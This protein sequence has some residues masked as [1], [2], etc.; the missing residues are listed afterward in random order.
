MIHVLFSSSAAGTLR[1]VLRTRG[2]GHEK[3]IDLTELLDWGPIGSGDPQ[4]RVRWLDRNVPS[5]F[6]GGWDWLAEHVAEFEQRVAEEPDRLI[7]IEPYS[8]GE[9]SGLYWYLERFAGSD[10]QMLIAPQ[11][12]GL[13][14]LGIRGPESMADLLDNCPRVPWEHGRFPADHW[15]ALRAENL[16]LR[17]GNDG[18]LLST[19]SDYFDHFLLERCSSEWTPWMRVVGNAMIDIGDA[20]HR[21]DDVFLRWRLRELILREMIAS[22]GDMP[23][24]GAQ[25]DTLVRL[26]G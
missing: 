2:G 19:A 22:N 21:I 12:E 10:T 11:F 23:L 9:L 17:I 15:T 20:G 18:A 1:Q 26:P 14:G 6:P 16:L 4:E 7:W 24:Y 8:A 25:S 13:I 5:N 3:V